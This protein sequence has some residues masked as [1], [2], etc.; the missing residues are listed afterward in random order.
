MK[1]EET[2]DQLNLLFS[3]V[4]IGTGGRRPYGWLDEPIDDSSLP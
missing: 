3:L 1:S 4:S 2:I